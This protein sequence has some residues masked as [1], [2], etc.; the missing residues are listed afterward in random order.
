[1]ASIIYFLL[2]PPIK[3]FHLQHFDFLSFYMQDFSDEKPLAW[4]HFT[5]EGDVEF[6]AVLFVPPKAP[7]DLYE[8]YYNN[9]SN[10]KLYVRRVFISDEFDELLPKYLS[11]L[12]VMVIAGISIYSDVIQHLIT[13]AHSLSSCRVLLIPTHYRSMY[14]VKCFSSTTVSRQSRKS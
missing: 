6:K 14:H 10:L 3:Y 2:F 12:K 5:A 7:H 1:M 4:S 8:S 11:F 13:N 9:K